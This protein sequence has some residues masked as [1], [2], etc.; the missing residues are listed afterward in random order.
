VVDI[1]HVQ[2][3]IWFRKR[4]SLKRLHIIVLQ[5]VHKE[6]FAYVIRSASGGTFMWRSAI[7]MIFYCAKNNRLIHNLLYIELVL[8]LEFFWNRKHNEINNMINSVYW[9]LKYLSIIYIH[10]STKVFPIFLIRFAFVFHYLSLWFG[11]EFICI[12]QS[13]MHT[14]ALILN[15]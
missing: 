8:L 1:Y 7:A 12:F 2:L 15:I 10:D 3:L 9:Y 6:I 5:N 13:N 14:N 4:C 11:F